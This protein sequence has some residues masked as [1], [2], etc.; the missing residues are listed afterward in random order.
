MGKLFTMKMFEEMHKL[1]YDF[2]VSSDLTR[3]LD[4]A[5]WFFVKKTVSRSHREVVCIAPG[6][7]DTLVLLEAS[8]KIEEVVKNAIKDA[9]PY[10]IQDEKKVDSCG[11]TLTE[12]KLNG[13]PWMDDDGPQ[14]V[15]T[16]ELVMS[17]ISAMGSIN[18]RL[19]AGTNI[20]G[21]TDSYFFM[22]DPDYST[23]AASMCMI[24][25]NKE[26][27]LRLINCTEMAAS[28]EDT[29]TKHY[30]KLAEQED[31]YG[32]WEFKLQGS[33]FI[34]SGDVAIRVR[35]LMSR[36]NETMMAHG[37]AL[38]T[39]LDIS[40]KKDDKSILLFHKAPSSAAKF[41]CIF[42][43]DTHRIR[44]LDFPPSHAE[45]LKEE[46]RRSY[47]PGFKKKQKESDVDSCVQVEL[48][49]NPWHYI[50]PYNLYARSAML[51]VLKKANS[52]GWDLVSSTDIS[53]KCVIANDPGGYKMD[54][55]SW[56]FVYK[57][58]QTGGSINSE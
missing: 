21:G 50:M 3:M 46:L 56:Y 20:K 49:G 45:E 37:W 58:H 29:I 4:Q 34:S 17:I 23:T 39:S 24:S 26:N 30:G 5:S 6:E 28:V 15:R 51:N 53:S 25:L 43:S 38:S 12:I 42:L 14:N 54:V 16:R 7:M 18:Y 32:S 41:A 35:K 44:L 2:V 27:R 57:H 8:T 36:I 40:R 31:K 47:L 11:K 10:G 13:N 19:H 52:L 48:Y 22:H 55:H 33:P 9:W 1:G